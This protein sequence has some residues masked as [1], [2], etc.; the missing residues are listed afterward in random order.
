M[1]RARERTSATLAAWAPALAAATACVLFVAAIHRASPRTLVSFHGL[2][3]AALAQR[4][5]DPETATFP[6]ENPFFAGEPVPYY[7]FYQFVAAQLVRGFGWNV[8]HA[9]ESVVLAATA[10]LILAGVALGRALYGS[11]LAGGLVAYLVL[12]GTNAFGFLFAGLKVALQGSALLEEDPGYLWNVVHPVYSL[13]RYADPGGLYGPLLNFFLNITSRPAALAA[14]LVTVLLLERTLR[15]PTWPRC[16]GLVLAAAA[17]TAFSP[18]VG[19][20]AAGVLLAASTV[21]PLAERWTPRLWGGL[22]PAAGP[23]A[24]RRVAAALVA[25]SLLA[26]PTYAHLLTGPSARGMRFALDS[27]PGLHHLLT[28]ALS[29]LVLLVLAV[30]GWRRS[31]PG[32]RGFAGTLLMAG[33]LLLL[34]TVTVHLPEGNE[35]NFFHAAVVLLAV[36]AA[37]SVLRRA[38]ADGRPVVSRARAGAVVLVFLPTL[39]LLVSAYLDRPPIPVAFGD[40]RPTRLPQRSD[41]ARFYAWAQRETPADAVFVVDPRSRVAVC[42][43]TAELPAMTGRTLFT[44]ESAHYVVEPYPDSIMRVEI[45]LRLTG[46]VPLEGVQRS[47]VQSLGRPVFIVRQETTKAAPLQRMHGLLGA[48]LF[49]AGEISVFRWHRNGEVA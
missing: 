24:R 34:A 11:A 29:S 39:L 30:V 36:P 27:A 10:T 41:L 31:P 8:F 17:T 25:G 2:L 38:Q 20:P 48:P 14:L 19:I 47:Y 46:G 45:A 42:G 12:A 4:F 9:L 37:G 22:T 23:R 21:G 15:S 44:E 40:E 18:V 28:V 3:H 5:L 7:W 16:A 49:H 13:I 43:N 6:P 32:A 35:S 1:A 26:A 33:C